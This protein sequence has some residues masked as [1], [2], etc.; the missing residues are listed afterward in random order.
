[1]IEWIVPAVLGV[2]A[3][4]AL[5]DEM[6]C[7]KRSKRTLRSIDS[8]LTEIRH[9]GERRNDWKRVSSKLSQRQNTGA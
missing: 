3:L 8:D 4:I 7:S 6:R 9:I 5:V 2:V 1:M